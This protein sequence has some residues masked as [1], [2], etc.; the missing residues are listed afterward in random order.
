MRDSVEAIRDS[1]VAA[2]LPSLPFEG[3]GREMLER[4]AIAAGHEAQMVRA[5]F[6]G[7]AAQAVAHFSDM[8]DRKALEKLAGV[9]IS[10]L[11]VRDRIRL[12]VLTRLELLRPRRDAVRQSLSWWLATL[13]C[14]GGLGALWRTADRIW[15]W[16]GDESRDYNRYTKRILLSGVI[17]STTL[18]WLEDSSADM[19]KTKAFLD[20]RIENVMQSGKMIGRVRKAL[21][22]GKEGVSA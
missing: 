15:L 16:A 3:W 10:L 11:R 7:G 22:F 2:A 1:I 8:A 5:V 9:D 12:G 18:V 13:R 20:R 19:A 14:A 21:R 6:P 4:A 17:A